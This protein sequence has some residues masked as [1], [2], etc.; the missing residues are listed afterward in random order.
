MGVG[1]ELAYERAEYIHQFAQRSQQEIAGT[2]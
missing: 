1:E 2:K